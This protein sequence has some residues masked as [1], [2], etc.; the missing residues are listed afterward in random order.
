MI[1][2]KITL[3]NF[4]SYKNGEFE[5]S[6]GL[7]VIS[8]TIGSGKTSL[9]EAFQWLVEKKSGDLIDDRFVLNKHS[10]KTTQEGEE[11][12]V[13]VGLVYEINK[14]EHTL[15]K[16]HV[17]KKHSKKL[18]FERE[19]YKDTH[20][21]RITKEAIIEKDANLVI[22]KIQKQLFPQ[23]IRQYILFKGEELDKL[24]DF[25]NP[26]T[27]KSAV[28]RIS[29]LKYYKKIL[30]HSQE[31][32]EKLKRKLER[33]IKIADQDKKK[34]DKIDSEIIEVNNNIKKN[35]TAL[36]QTEKT[37]EGLE[38][39]RDKLLNAIKNAGNYHIIESNLDQKQK[40]MKEIGEKIAKNNNWFNKNFLSKL[41]VS[42]IEGALQKAEF[43]FEKF[44]KTWQKN[45]ASANKTL[46]LGFP[47]PALINEMLNDC[48]CVFCGTE[49]TKND[50]K[51]KKIES[52]KDKNKLQNQAL[53]KEED[54]ILNNTIQQ[55][56]GSVPTL[57]QSSHDSKNLWKNY[58][59]EK[60]TLNQEHAETSDEIESLKAEV[61]SLL[62]SNPA[63]S[64]QTNPQAEFMSIDD[65]LNKKRK[66]EISL[67]DQ[68]AKDN[69]E[70]LSLQHK[71]LALAQNPAQL[72]NSNEQKAIDYVTYI[73]QLS[74]KKI[75]E[76][77]LMFIQNI[78]ESTNKMQR[79]IIES[80]NKN[81]A[82]LFSKIDPDTLSV[83][84]IDT[85]G[86]PNPGHG[87]QQTLS[88]LA[89]ISSVL[90]LSNEKVQEAFPFIVDAPSSNFDHTIVGPFME[91]LS[92]NLEQSIVITKDVD[93]DVDKYV[94]ESFI[95][96]MY[97]INIEKVDSKQSATENIYTNIE[98]LK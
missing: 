23:Q 28:D 57:L 82:V 10:A 95:R 86:K 14:Q 69:N 17:Y 24:I 18:V 12:E 25:T 55:L 33:Q 30:K 19:T 54:R 77:K 4:K 72:N 48:V 32:L 50:E 94:K 51:Y 73:Q 64:G 43:E 65:Q 16:T 89:I 5:F 56:K 44:N 36:E 98:K 68:L 2:K 38:E 88:K 79:E 85:N 90:K 63:L 84:H 78:E 3:K 87:A 59:E 47:G 66:T 74:E 35:K 60:I 83:E 1:I 9:F 27:L 45:I 61:S 42:G 11:V 67:K 34:K 71:K 70:L 53:M 92:K 75:K 40:E 26:Q 8:G 20:K 15:S 62:S 49:F 29:Y 58:L 21:H 13:L 91:S 41:M 39:S 31:I 81:L 7:N 97:K 46:Q 52:H 37:I 6:L 76:E 80:G 22:S 93:R 96:R